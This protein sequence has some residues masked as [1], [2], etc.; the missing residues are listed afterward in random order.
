M[1]KKDK[2]TKNK[3][4]GQ[5]QISV[6]LT[7]MFVTLLV[8]SILVSEFLV[9]VFGF[10][11]VKDLIDTS[12]TNQV[13]T[14]SATVNRD[15]NSTF[16][17]L[18]GVADAVEQNTYASND[19]IMQYL[20]G[21]VGRYEMIPTGAYLTLNDETFLYPSSPDFTMDNI[22]EHD[23]YKQALGYDNSWFYFYDQPYFDAVTNDLCATVIR[24][25]HMKDGREGCFAADLML[26]SSQKLLNEVKLYET[27][28]AMMV[29][30][31]GLILTYR[32][33]ES[34]CG[35]NLADIDN[36]LVKVVGEFAVSE[37]AA[38]LDPGVVTGLK[39]NGEKYYAVSAGVSGTD[40]RVVIYAKQAEVLATLQKLIGML[41]LI[42]II[43]VALVILIITRSLKKMIKMPVTSLTDNIQKISSGDFTV[44]ID[45]GK[46]ND[47]IAYMNT[48]MGDFI[49]GMR[50]SLSEIKD[51]SGRL[52]GD[53][54]A[55][56]S[57]AEDLEAAAIDQSSSMS[58]IKDNIENMAKA[59]SEVAENATVLAQTVANVTEQ[60]HQIETSM[61]ELV[62]KADSGQHDMT[63][64]ANGMS[65]IVESMKDMAEAVSNVDE[66]AEKITQIIDLINSISSQTNL[67][68]LNASIEAARAGEMGK[69]FAVVAAEIGT[70]A[71]NSADATNQI[72]EIIKDM[73]QKVHMLSEKSE[74]NTELINTS[75]E[76]V[77]T[78]AA[79][80]SAITEELSNANV[81]L[82]EMAEQMQKVND[83]A[84]NMASVS[85]EQSASTQEIADNVDRVTEAAK[86]VAS[87]SE[88]V[89]SAASSVSD[90]VDTINDNLEQFTI[91]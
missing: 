27:G 3:N 26:G 71:Q 73:S 48:V 19:D 64:V 11:M 80:F 6:K 10:N 34:L 20:S 49:H 75:A 84:T 70:L 9:L 50:N 7:I 31:S 58:Q 89:A 41:I 88:L 45:P 79:T 65:D 57:T 78:A 25:V 83:V 4:A 13:T 23:W 51:V 18:N 8:L 44:D 86:G 32:D 85:E 63:T 15:L 74:S 81:T 77:N 46:G 52:H 54:Q 91:K 47:E 82:T 61:N 59:V 56:K 16:T 30:G 67:L 42:T 1:N 17:Y 40:W 38:E 43:S 35:Q 5:K 55:S 76:T 68:S 69:G 66:A 37:G 22:L 39:A 36:E 33:D 60:E 53:A 24:H 14:S 62:K 87:S 2:T 28:G 29:T 90:A 21:T 12:L 72:A